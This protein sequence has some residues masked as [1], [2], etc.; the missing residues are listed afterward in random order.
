MNHR[1]VKGLLLAAAIVL[2]GAALAKEATTPPPGQ[3]A[4]TGNAVFT[5]DT[6]D[7]VDAIQSPRDAASGQATGMKQQ[8]PAAGRH[9]NGYS[10]G[11]TQTG[12]VQAANNRMGDTA[13]HEAGHAV[14][15][16]APGG[17]APQPNAIQVIA[18]SHEV[19][20]QPGTETGG[21]ASGLAT[22]RRTYEPIA[23]A[24][25]QGLSETNKILDVVQPNTQADTKAFREGGV[26]DT[27]HRKSR[28]N[29]NGTRGKRM[30]KP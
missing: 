2:P 23:G 22:G 28:S 7:K 24:Q 16:N 5:N 17:T 27:R 25:P 4:Q 10:F 9:P 11:A 18:V 15:A 8:D 14:G 3:P 12:S 26:N 19:V 30:H 6:I 13:T 29:R 1:T 20:A 21:G